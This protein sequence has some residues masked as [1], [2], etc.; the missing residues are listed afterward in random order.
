MARVAAL[1]AL[2]MVSI[3]IYKTYQIE[4]GKDVQ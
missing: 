3:L 4:V 2:L 1:A